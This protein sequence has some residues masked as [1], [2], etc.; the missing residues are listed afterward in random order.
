MYFLLSNCSFFIS[1]NKSYFSFFIIRERSHS[2]FLM[3]LLMIS[4]TPYNKV[5]AQEIE[6]DLNK[7]AIPLFINTVSVL[8]IAFIVITIGQ[9]FQS[10]TQNGKYLGAIPPQKFKN[11]VPVQ[12]IGDIPAPLEDFINVYQKL[13]HRKKKRFSRI[14]AFFGK[15]I[16]EDLEKEK[17]QLFFDAYILHGPSG[18]GKTVT[19]GYIVD[20]LQAPT[21]VFSQSHINSLVGGGPNNMKA[22]H[23]AVVAAAE[24][25]PIGVALVVCDEFDSWAKERIGYGAEETLN[26]FLQLI[27]GL[28]SKRHVKILWLC[29]TNLLK[30]IDKAAKSRVK[31]VEFSTPR[32]Q[33]FKIIGLEHFQGLC[34][35]VD[36]LPP[37]IE[38]LLTQKIYS[39][40]TDELLGPRDIKL[41]ST[42]LKQ[43]KF[44]QGESFNFDK[45]F[46]E[47][48]E[49]RKKRGKQYLIE[50]YNGKQRNK[51]IID[52]PD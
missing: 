52:N 46:A 47:H 9:F 39:K 11:T 34:D 6:P 7:I 3:I 13:P 28:E 10:R 12:N 38:S 26:R 5:Q 40:K 29:V 19:T 8:M 51:N 24:T 49:V 18:T 2:F 50:L 20:R 17:E 32:P 14:R 15:S 33:T 21:F 42:E 36:Y 27:D 44:L 22:M 30:F 23:D 4:I 45:V 48:W 25:N 31:I 35:G 43:Q 41:I 1:K 37:Q 16:Y